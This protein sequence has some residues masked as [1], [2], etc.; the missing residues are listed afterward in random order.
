MQEIEARA[1]ETVRRACGFAA[2][3]IFATMIGLS[4][5]PPVAAQAGA[6]LSSLMVAVLFLKAWE[7]PNRPYR[8]TELWTILDERH[9]PPPGL[10]QRILM[11]TLQETYLRYA[12]AVAVL[13]GGLWVLSLLLSLAL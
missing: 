12:R 1:E 4:F 8:R 7:A 13:A 5:D 2:F 3:G 11:N 10:A 6:I 9:R